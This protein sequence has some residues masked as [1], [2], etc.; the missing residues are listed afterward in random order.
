MKSF[1]RLGTFLGWQGPTK[2]ITYLHVSLFNFHTEIFI[3]EYCKIYLIYSSLPQLV[4]KVHAHYN[5]LSFWYEVHWFLD[6]RNVTNIHILLLFLF[7]FMPDGFV[8]V[9]DW[10]KTSMVIHLLDNLPDTVHWTWKVCSVIFL[11]ILILSNGLIFS[12]EW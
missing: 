5:L 11:V 6:K 10:T 3:H 4:C 7:L 12:G 1:Q 9:P 2:Q 8:W